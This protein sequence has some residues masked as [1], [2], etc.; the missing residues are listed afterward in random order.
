MKMYQ[1]KDSEV[2]AEIP[3]KNNFT[4]KA[5]DFVKILLDVQYGRTWLAHNSVKKED[6][7]MFFFTNSEL[8]EIKSILP[9]TE[10]LKQN[11]YGCYS[12]MQSVYERLMHRMSCNQ[13]NSAITIM[14]GMRSMYESLEDKYNCIN[15][16]LSKYS[17]QTTEI[18]QAIVKFKK[19]IKQPLKHKQSKYSKRK[20]KR[21]FN[22]KTRKPSYLSVALHYF[23]LQTS[24]KN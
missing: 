18:E 6:L 23:S 3:C 21:L 11:L 8:E 16:I 7:R 10:N 14:N 1:G 22:K 17:P 4:I 19:C 9:F 24:G 20:V 5:G 15:R 2:I 12:L 13:I